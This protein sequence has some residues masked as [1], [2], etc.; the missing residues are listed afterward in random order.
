MS[1]VSVP[2]AVRESPAGGAVESRRAWRRDG[3][4]CL[5]ALLPA[6]KWG[7]AADTHPGQIANHIGP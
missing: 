6:T 5:A 7:Q 1:D 4:A 3:I 2:L